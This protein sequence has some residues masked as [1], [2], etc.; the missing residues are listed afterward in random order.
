MAV[1]SYFNRNLTRM[2][3]YG[4]HRRDEYGVKIKSI[5]MDDAA[6]YYGEK[7][8]DVAEEARGN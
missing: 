2:G 5:D 8:D 7:E 4:G 1:D 6:L 3:L